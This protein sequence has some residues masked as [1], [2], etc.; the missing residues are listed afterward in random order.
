MAQ[1]WEKLD[2]GSSASFVIFST[3]F[4]RYVFSKYIASSIW[5]K[6]QKIFGKCVA[7]HQITSSVNQVFEMD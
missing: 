2:E 7:S 4:Y 6:K 3:Q 1:K 5:Y